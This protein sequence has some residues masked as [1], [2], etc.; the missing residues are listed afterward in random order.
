MNYRTLEYLEKLQNEPKGEKNQ[1]RTNIKTTFYKAQSG[2]MEAFDFL[3]KTNEYLINEVL[4][5]GT[6]YINLDIDIQV[7]ID[8]LT[9]RLIRSIE[10]F[11]PTNCV[12]F[13]TFAKR[14]LFCRLMDYQRYHKTL[15]YTLKTT[16]SASEYDY[17]SDEETYPLAKDISNAAQDNIVLNE[18]NELIAVDNAKALWDKIET[19]L[20]EK[21]RE[22]LYNHF[23]LGK[24]CEEIASEQNYCRQL[25]SI[26]INNAINRVKKEVQLANKVFTAIEYNKLSIKEIMTK[27]NIKQEEKITYYYQL[28]Q[29]LYFDGPIPDSVDTYGYIMYANKYDQLMT[30]K[31]SSKKATNELV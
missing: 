18:Y 17:I 6:Q 9:D 3:Y 10:D 23:I 27:L 16:S 4:R 11:D 22:Y 14:N 12:A 1:N 20:N 28:Y 25:I 19:L 13:R 24:T 29:Y 7:Y 30:K 15:Q 2:D 21:E 26:K 8:L 5:E 31:Y